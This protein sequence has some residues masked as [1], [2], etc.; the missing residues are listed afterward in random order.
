MRRLQQLIRTT[1]K[2]DKKNQKTFMNLSDQVI[3]IQNVQMVD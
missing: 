3:K 1:K 2:M